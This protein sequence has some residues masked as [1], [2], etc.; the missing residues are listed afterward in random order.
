MRN[1]LGIEPFENGFQTI[2]GRK[3]S[4]LI[5]I[6][7]AKLLQQLVVLID[8]WVILKSWNLVRLIRSNESPL[9]L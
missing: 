7:I 8:P 1:Y 5:P 3:T 4:N 2:L 9:T 6:W